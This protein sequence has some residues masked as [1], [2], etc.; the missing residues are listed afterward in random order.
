MALSLNNNNC[1]LN[2]F[3]IITEPTVN[4]TKS[5][6]LVNTPSNKTI[7]IKD[8][9]THQHVIT[10]KIDELTTVSHIKAIISNETSVPVEDQCLYYGNRNCS[11]SERL[12]YCNFP[13]GKTTFDLVV[14]KFCV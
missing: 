1:N 5:A 11:D 7:N 12:F 13:N 9:S 3:V 10:L 14:C 2:C 4:D 8:S 6:P